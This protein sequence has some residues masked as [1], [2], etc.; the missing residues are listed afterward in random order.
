MTDEFR[1]NMNVSQQLKGF[2]HIVT[3]D[4][5]CEDMLL[6]N[7]LDFHKHYPYINLKF[8]NADT[9]DM[10]DMLDRNEADIIMTLDTHNYRSDYVIAKE[11]HVDMPFVANADS[12]FA[13]QKKLSVNDIAE[14]PFILDRKGY[15]LPPYS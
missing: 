6:T 4:S 15:G 11:E 8:T 7:Y 14:Q 1:Q 9:G 10:F 12:L 5:V 3:P 2:I 13:G